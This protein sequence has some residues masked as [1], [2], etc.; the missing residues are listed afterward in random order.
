VN[1]P[2]PAPGTILIADD[3]RVNRL[4]LARGLEQQGHA[5]AFAGHGGEALDL[6][7][8]QPF[9][10]MLLDVL[11]PELDGYEVLAKLKDDPLLRDIPVIVT[12]A[13]DELDSV[14]R[15][16]EMGAED[17]LT[18]PVNPV[19]LNARINASLEKKRLRDQQR[20]LI[21][22]FATKE[23]ADDLLTSGFSLG[24]QYVEASA[25]FCD[26]RSFTTISESREP[27]ETIELLN[28][29]YL[30]MM[31]AIAGEG[32]IVNQMIGD[33]LMAIFGAPAPREDHRQAAVLAAR[34]MV[35]LIR[36]FNEE[37]A[38]RDKVQI[39]IGVGIASGRVVAGYTGTSNRATYTCVG[40]TVNVAARLEAHTKELGRPILIDENTRQGIDDGIAVEAQGEMLMKGKTE[41][42]AVYAVLVDAMVAETA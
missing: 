19:L 18:K 17:Y 15:C 38:A 30:L 23:V 12:S 32:G 6:L 21:S 1:S 39:E 20:E 37:Q 35:E 25:M 2:A 14:V 24:G 31:D 34:Q 7:R 29:Y 9:D 26:I 16:L 3:N 8:Q 28:D 36:L 42:I 4:M 10:L 40:D 13:L 41:P 11:M 33:G 27:A 5:V 22:K